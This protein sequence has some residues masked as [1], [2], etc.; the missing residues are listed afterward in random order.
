MVKVTAYRKELKARILKEAMKEF[1]KQGIRRVKMDDIARA[2]SISKR[3]LY[4][5]YSNKEDL[6]VESLKAERERYKAATDKYLKD[7]ER[8]VID[9]LI[10]FVRLEMESLAAVSTAFFSDIQK[11]PKAVSFLRSI[12]RENNRQSKGF[13]DKGIS[14]GIFRPDVDYGI[15]SNVGQAAMHYVIDNNL[16]KHYSAQDLFRNIIFLLIRGICTPKGVKLF[17]LTARELP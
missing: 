4:E 12:E 9:V 5:L 10:F 1:K 11:Y 8:S 6:L 7:G 2:L 3:T 15:V 17:D 13:F 14:D 16:V